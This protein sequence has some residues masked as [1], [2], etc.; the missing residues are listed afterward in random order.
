MQDKIQE[1]GQE[2]TRLNGTRRS[3]AESKFEEKKWVGRAVLFIPHQLGQ[4]THAHHELLRV[5][6]DRMCR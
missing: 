6:L 1:L 5:L 2:V 4:K 3:A